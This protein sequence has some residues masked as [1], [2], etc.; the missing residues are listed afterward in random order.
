MP[1]I[2]LLHR[3]LPGIR[4]ACTSNDKQRTTR[5]PFTVPCLARAKT[6]WRRGC[7]RSREDSGRTW[8][9]S[10]TP[11]TSTGSAAGIRARGGSSVGGLASGS[12]FRT[13]AS[14][15]ATRCATGSRAIHI[16]LRIF[17]YSNEYMYRLAGVGYIV[18]ILLFYLL[19]FWSEYYAGCTA[20]H[21]AKNGNCD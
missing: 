1:G 9:S 16:C 4:F 11:G 10:T 2:A 20:R 13:F 14:I 12:L 7:T 5:P 17:L 3:A 18:Y 8:S 15:G 6:L 21:M 19:L